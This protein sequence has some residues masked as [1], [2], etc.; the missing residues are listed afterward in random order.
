MPEGSQREMQTQ[1]VR[2]EIHQQQSSNGHKG[3]WCNQLDIK[4]DTALCELIVNGVKP[5]R[6]ERNKEQAEQDKAS[7]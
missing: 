3:L 5:R 7:R 1:A 2:D 6:C 4:T